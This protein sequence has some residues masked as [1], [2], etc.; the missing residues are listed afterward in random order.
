MNGPSALGSRPHSRLKSFAFVSVN[1]IYSSGL[2][3]S[4]LLNFLKEC[5]NLEMVDDGMTVGDKT[6]PWI[7]YGHQ[8]ADVL[9]PVLKTQHIRILS[10]GCVPD[11]AKQDSSLA[12]E[13]LKRDQRKD[14]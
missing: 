9:L 6:S 14:G 10:A 5:D 12:Q 2:L 8:L 3:K 4:I 11:Y 7:N 1:G 13:I